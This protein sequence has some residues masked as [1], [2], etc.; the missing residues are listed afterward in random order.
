MALATT[1]KKKFKKGP[2][3]GNNPKGE[4]K[5]DMRKVKCFACHK[6][7]HY[8]GQCLNKKKKQTKTSAT[9]E[10]FSPS[11]TSNFPWLCVYP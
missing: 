6:F 8:A 5:K 2:K 7:G 11:L 4:G 1:S 10:E 9:V 3:G